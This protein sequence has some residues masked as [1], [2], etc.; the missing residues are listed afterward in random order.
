MNLERHISVARG[1]QP[2]DLVI[3]G[4]SLVNVFSGEIYRTDIAIADGRVVGLGDYE[5]LEIYEATD[6]YAAPGFIDAHLHLE[7]TCL[8]VPE[9][10]RAVVPLGT[11]TVVA[12]PHEIANV[13]GLDGIAYMLESSRGLPLRVYYMLPSCVPV[14]EL[15]TAGARLDAQDLAPLLEHPQVLGLAEVMN[16]PG[17]LAKDRKMLAKIGLAR[18]RPIDGH[19]PGLSGRDLCA[20]VGAGIRSDHECTASQEAIEKVR[21]GMR[22]LIREG[23]VAKNLVALLPAVTPPSLVQ[24]GL[25]SDDRHPDDL[26]AEGHMNGLLKKAVALGLSPVAAIQLITINP[27]RF[28][29]LAEIG[30]IAPGY[31]AD[32]VL[33]KDLRA[34]QAVAVF[35]DGRLVAEHGRLLMALPPTPPG[36][37]A[38][39]KIGWDRIK[40]FEIPA[41]G[42]EGA[43]GRVID[44][45]PDQLVTREVVLPLTIRN[46]VAVADPERDLAK[47]AVVER[48]N[49]TGNVGLGFVHGLGLR[50]GAM[51]SSVAHD[52]HNVVVAGMNDADMLAAVQAVERHGGGL[53]VAQERRVLAA[54]PLPIAGLLSDL[55]LERVAAQMADALAAAR[56]LGSPLR[57]PFMTLS[58]LALP[59]IPELKLTDRGLV[60]VAR[61]A[62]VPLFIEP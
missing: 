21:L 43:R 17:V 47:L 25:V 9:F 28:F 31:R 40:G 26:L 5:G 29:S 39:F 22:V 55:S 14:T 52:S 50:Q 35:K 60:D 56:T 33:L 6:C 61:A 13:A 24:F 30:A 7:S 51:A 38:A 20:Y 15:E 54:V 46:G 19:A 27:A 62:V 2:A 41:P 18:G 37:N 4:C 57:N 58:F 59:A 53:V 11:T 49:G 36:P 45:I 34:F 44:V 42:R 1:E 23:S 10:A 32:L 8:T 16:Y 48:H 12:D 3:R